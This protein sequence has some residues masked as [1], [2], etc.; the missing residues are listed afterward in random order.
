MVAER[1]RAARMPSKPEGD[2]NVGV[3]RIDDWKKL[4]LYVYT[5]EG[6]LGAIE[7]SEYNAWVLVG[8]LTL[9]LG[10]SLPKRLAER[11]KL[12]TRDGKWSLRIS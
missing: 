11:I 9:M 7:V 12:P 8:Y 6:E 4:R 5:D 10:I 3:R 1:K 2:P